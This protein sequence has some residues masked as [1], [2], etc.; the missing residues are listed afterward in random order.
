MLCSN[1]EKERQMTINIKIDEKD[2]NKLIGINELL[3][4]LSHAR[5]QDGLIS[6]C[7][8]CAIRFLSEILDDV[9]V[10]MS[11]QVDADEESRRERRLQ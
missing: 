10:K 5:H 11:K 3:Y 1:M 6:N 9:V 7:A 4:L 2:L 8:E